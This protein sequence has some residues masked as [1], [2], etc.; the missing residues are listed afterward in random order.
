MKKRAFENENLKIQSS[1]KC[2]ARKKFRRA[3][4]DLYVSKEFFMQRSSWDE[5]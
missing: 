4:Y 5:I 1:H 2:K 3:A